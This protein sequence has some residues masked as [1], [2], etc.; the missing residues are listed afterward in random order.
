MSQLQIDGW[1]LFSR[2]DG[3]HRSARSE[4]TEIPTDRINSPNN[5]VSHPSVSA[6]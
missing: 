1:L 6:R 3:K 5:T 4:N 2:D